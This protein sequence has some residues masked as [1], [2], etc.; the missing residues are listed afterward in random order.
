MQAWLGQIEQHANEDVLKILVATKCDDEDHRQ[1]TND[2]AEAFAREHGISLFFT[3]AHSGLN[4]AEA[5]DSIARLAV[6]KQSA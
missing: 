2:M 1:V 4:V 3:S 5:F 6:D